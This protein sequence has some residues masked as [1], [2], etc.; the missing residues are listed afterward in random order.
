MYIIIL[1]D[2]GVKQCSNLP[3]AGT[4]E[5]CSKGDCDIIDITNQRMPMQW[6]N[7]WIDLEEAEQK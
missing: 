3:D 7:G 5:A 6:C 4:F 2:G 1:E